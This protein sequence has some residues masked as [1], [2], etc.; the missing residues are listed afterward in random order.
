MVTTLLIS[1]TNLVS[2]RLVV[3]SGPQLTSELY[4]CS[5]L[6]IPNYG[7]RPKSLFITRIPPKTKTSHK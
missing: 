4:K 2:K 1:Y 3:E 6:Y 7:F 5:M